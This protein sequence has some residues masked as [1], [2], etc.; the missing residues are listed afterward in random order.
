MFKSVMRASSSLTILAEFAE[1]PKGVQTCPRPHRLL[2]CSASDQH[3][4]L[5]QG[6]AFYGHGF[7]PAS[8]Y[9]S[10]AAS[11]KPVENGFRQCDRLLQKPATA[12]QFIRGSGPLARHPQGS[13]RCPGGPE[14]TCEGPEQ[15]QRAPRFQRRSRAMLV[16]YRMNYLQVAD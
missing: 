4:G 9:S 12:K 2:D 10:Q 11:P 1:V 6:I 14:R 13:A 5:H 3:K 8:D 16:T 7:G 15:S